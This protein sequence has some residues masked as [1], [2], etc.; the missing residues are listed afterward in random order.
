MLII[1]VSRHITQFFDNDLSLL[2]ARIATIFRGWFLFSV[3]FSNLFFS[4]EF[5]PFWW[6]RLEFPRDSSMILLF[7]FFLNLS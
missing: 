3:K 2:T 7:E 5:Q 6:P 4:E 1:V